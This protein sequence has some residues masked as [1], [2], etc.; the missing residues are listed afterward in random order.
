M[1]SLQKRANEARRLHEEAVRREEARKREEAEAKERAQAAKL[2]REVV[3]AFFKAVKLLLPKPE[4]SELV[5]NSRL[6]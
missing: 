2:H 4:F 5:Q 3:E 1:A 6:I